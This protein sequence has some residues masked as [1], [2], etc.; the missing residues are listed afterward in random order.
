MKYLILFFYLSTLTAQALQLEFYQKLEIPYKTIFNKTEIGGLSA[1]WFDENENKLFAVSDDKGKIHEPR[2]YSFQLNL[3]KEVSIQPTEVFFLKKIPYS[4]IDMEGLT[5]LP[6]GNFLVSTEGDN[7]KK[8]R[9]PPQLLDIKKDGTVVREFQIPDAF[10]PENSGEQKKGIRNN[11]GFEG[12]TRSASG[13]VFWMTHESPLLQEV[14]PN[15][16]K[17]LQ[18]EML[19]AW[20]LKKTKEYDY[21]IEETNDSL[22]NGVTE[23][24]GHNED[25]LL[26]LERSISLTT[27]GTEY[28]VKLFLFDLVSSKKQLL[29]DFKNIEGNVENFEGLSWGPN[30]DGKKTL[31]VISDNNFK[32]TERTLLYIFKLKEGK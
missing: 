27:K 25:Q 18:Y 13:K 8:P 9:I 3:Q 5:V 12:L 20:V 4:S 2:I 10:I 15:I 23:I 19:E 14:R 31:L 17:I 16:V 21:P 1:I 29:F 32:K 24:L 28:K 22:F 26:V 11:L 6:W 30:I 7:N